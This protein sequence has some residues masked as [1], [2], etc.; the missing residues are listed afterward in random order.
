VQQ[1]LRALMPT[2][3]RTDDGH[4]ACRRFRAAERREW[5]ELL[6]EALSS[7]RVLAERNDADADAIDVAIVANPR[8]G[9]LQGFAGG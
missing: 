3:Q 6:L 5:L 1:A 7:E 8:G 9:A 4:P 2:S